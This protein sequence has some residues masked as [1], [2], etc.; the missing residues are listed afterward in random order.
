MVDELNIGFTNILP[1]N[2]LILF[3]P[4]LPAESGIFFYFCCQLTSVLTIHGTGLNID[5]CGSGLIHVDRWSSLFSGDGRRDPFAAAGAGWVWLAVEETVVISTGKGLIKPRL[6]K[7][8][9]FPSFIGRGAFK[10]EKPCV[11]NNHS[12]N[13][14][15]TGSTSY[16]S[17]ASLVWLDIKSSVYYKTSNFSNEF[18]ICLWKSPLLTPDFNSGSF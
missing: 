14:D 9:T 11:W 5:R 7:V 8:G 18:M 10:V 16:T 17:V 1:L 3:I 15:H 4:C 6:P 2:Q 13:W 12:F